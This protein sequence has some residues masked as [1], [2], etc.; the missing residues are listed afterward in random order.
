MNEKKEILIALK[1]LSEAITAAEKSISI[2]NL[3]RLDAAQTR[4]EEILEAL[5]DDLTN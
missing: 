5:K 2:I 3:T 1:E 4:A